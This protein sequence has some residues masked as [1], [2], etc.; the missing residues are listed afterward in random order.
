MLLLRTFKKKKL[1]KEM[2]LEINPSLTD[3]QAEFILAVSKHETANHTS[4]LF[5][6]YNNG[7][8]M[9]PSKK[10]ARFWDGVVYLNDEEFATYYQVEDSIRDFIGWFDFH[11]FKIPDNPIGVYGMKSRGYFTDSAENYY[12]A[13]K[14]YFNE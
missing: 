5:K 12:N 6:Q 13:V 4:R 1:T 11:G 9:K 3:R 7:F 8:G 14:K 2:I 10:R